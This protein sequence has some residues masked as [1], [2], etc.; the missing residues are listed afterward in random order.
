MRKQVNNLEFSSVIELLAAKRYKYFVNR[1]ADSSELWSLG[2]SSST[3]A[4]V[5]DQSEVLCLPVWPARE[6]AIAC[7]VGAWSE[8]VPR[9]FEVHCFLTEELVYCR[10]SAL[11]IAVFM[12][13][14]SYGIVRSP[15]E[16][17]ADVRAELERVE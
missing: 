5:S 17:E 8:Y 3:L 10:R 2:A 16:L 6:F 12:T 11:H 1:V 9:R 15:D 14:K 13:P 4:I 7:A